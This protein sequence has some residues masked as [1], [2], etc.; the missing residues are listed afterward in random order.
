MET[1]KKFVDNTRILGFKGKLPLV[2][3]IIDEQTSKNYENL[4]YSLNIL[5]EEIDTLTEQNSND[6]ILKYNKKHTQLN[7]NELQIY[8][9]YFESEDDTNISSF[10]ENQQL[11]ELSLDE[12]N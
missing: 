7:S 11:L 5:S 1:F 3:E 4:F 10:N 12:I 9:K 6:N 2:R 8:K